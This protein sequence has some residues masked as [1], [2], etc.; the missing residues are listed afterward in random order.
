[1]FKNMEK[2][3]EFSSTGKMADPVFIIIDK[4][5]EK[6]SN[7]ANR[8]VCSNPKYAFALLLKEF[9][10]CKND[11]GIGKG[12]IVSKDACLEDGISI[13]CNCLIEDGVTIGRGTKIYHNVVIREGTVIGRDCVVKSN[14]VIGEEGYGYSKCG[15]HIVHVP[16]FGHVVIEDGVEIG[17]NCSID[18]G[19]MENTVIGE[20]SK[21]DNLCHI[22][23]NVQ[24]GKNVMIVAHS[25]ICGSVCVKDNAY[26]APGGMIK[27][28]VEIGENCLVGMGSVV[29]DNTQGNKVYVGIPAKQLKDAK[30]VDL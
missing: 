21:I 14:T 7:Y 13:G 26:I 9:F 3:R 29:L 8:L 28:Q 1:M 20:G 6:A 5:V 10:E 2:Y 12:S 22:A 18:R 19:T 17:S 11:F 24:I 30:D 16:H 15:G 27:N 4:E 23:H 25:V